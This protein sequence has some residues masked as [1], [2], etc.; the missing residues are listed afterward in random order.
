MAVSIVRAYALA[1]LLTRQPN[2]PKISHDLDDHRL[3]DGDRRLREVEPT[4]QPNT[5]KM[6]K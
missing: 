3:A 4:N 2:L 6:E 1:K 5:T